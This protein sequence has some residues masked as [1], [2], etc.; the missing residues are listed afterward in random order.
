VNKKIL[1]ETQKIIDKEKNNILSFLTKLITIPTENPP[2]AFYKECIES[3]AKKLENINI[4]NKIIKVPGTETGKFPRYCLL[5]FHGSGKKTFYFHGHYDVVPAATKKQFQPSVKN[6]RL[7]GR[8]SSDM[9]GGLAAMIYAVKVIQELGIELNGRIGLTIVPDEETGGILG[10]KYLS[11]NNILG[12]DGIGI[13]LPEPTS[14]VVWNANRGALSLRITVRG[15]PAHVGLQHEG[16]NA[17]EKMLPV[18]HALRTLKTEVGQRK[19]AY[20]VQPDE[21]RNSILLMGGHVEG[22]KSFNTVPEKFSFTVDRRLNPE[23]DLAVEKQRFLDIFEKVKKEGTELEVEFLQE[24]EPAGTPDDGKLARILSK[25]I[26]EVTG[27]LPSF[28]MC[29][30]ILETRFYAKKGI[31]AF[32]Y[33]P[34]ILSVSHGP[35]EYINVENIYRCVKIYAVAALEMLM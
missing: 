2:G 3:I 27:S 7:Y 14:G 20:N 5:G 22:G 11:D 1:T 15:K 12:T 16:I 25:T 9:K 30:G 23:E 17:F 21:A 18:A 26:E 32:A 8:G 19:T 4:E 13:L 28:E 33:G 29:P 31:P 35:D 24:G 10:A 6:G 34:G